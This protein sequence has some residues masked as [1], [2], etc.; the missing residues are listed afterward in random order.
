VRKDKN[1]REKPAAVLGY[2]TG[3][4]SFT[5][6]KILKQNGLRSVKPTQKSGLTEAMMEARYQFC[7]RYQDW[8]LEDWKKVIWTDE[9]SV[10]LGARRGKRRVWRT[11]AEVYDK[12]CVRRRFKGYSK[13][14]W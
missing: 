10:V 1:G 9:T 13:F 5:I 3:L 8:T 11:S 12:T 6:L 7:L 4:S 2:E 14:M